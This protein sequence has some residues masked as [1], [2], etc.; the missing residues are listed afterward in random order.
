MRVTSTPNPAKA[1]MPRP[2]R[3]PAGQGGQ[4]GQGGRFPLFV[5]H[6]VLDTVSMTLE[7]TV[8]SQL[9]ATVSEGDF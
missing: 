7:T 3:P 4:P 2:P 8:G 5:I 1:D 9:S 6:M